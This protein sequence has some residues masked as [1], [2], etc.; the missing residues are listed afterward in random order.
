[1]ADAFIQPQGYARLNPAS[2][3]A[4]AAHAIV[5]GSVDVDV[6]TG[7]LLT[8]S[9]QFST[10]TPTL[11]ALARVSSPVGQA[12]A[13]RKGTWR[14]A[15]SRQVGTQSFVEFW[16][17]R[18]SSDFGNKG[19][20]ATDPTFATGSSNNA[21][22]I[23]TRMGNYS[24]GNAEHWGALYR[25]SD[26]FYG[27]GE[28][29]TPGVLTLL[30]VVRRQ[31][32]MELWRDGLLKRTVMVGPQNLGSCGLVV[33]AFLEN[34]Y[35]TSSSDMVLAGRSML[36]P[37]ADEIRAFSANLWSLFDAGEDQ[38]E[39]AAPAAYTLTAAGGAFAFTGQP[40]TLSTARR[41]AAA[42]GGFTLTTLAAS[43]LAA[44]RIVAAPAVLSLAGTAANLKAARRLPA[45]AGAVA[46]TG[47]A[48]KLTAA[49]KLTAAPAAFALTGGTA[50]FVYTPKPGGQGPTYTLTGGSGAFL[51][52]AT[53][54]RLLLAR[55]LV[56]TVG[57][58]SATGM[59]AALVA[60]RRLGALPGSFAFVGG[61]AGLRA[62]RRLAAGFGSFS[63]SGIAAK[64]ATARRL[65]ATT[66]SFAVAGTDALMKY[67]ANR[68]EID[69]D[70]STIP[71]NRT[72]V[73]GAFSRVVVFGANSRV[74]VF[75]GATRV[76]VF[77][78]PKIE[79][80]N[81]M[82]NAEEPY[83]VDGKWFCDKDP[84]EKS[85]FVADISKEL[86]KRHTTAVSVVVLTGGVTATEG[87]DIQGNLI[88]VKL[89]GMDVTDGA[90]NFWTARVTCA[91][92]EQFDRTTW[93]NK[94]DN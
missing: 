49:R 89:E 41:L 20:G 87:P 12:I 39:N 79:K 43:L 69:I 93:L 71:A 51:L 74:V 59:P 9:G 57:A 3:I 21:A 47:A 92:T 4:M 81:S 13:F 29:L 85:Y 23:V 36:D 25:W 38:D 46:L 26:V 45:A 22:A 88:V 30:V 72:V 65:P 78:D 90:D 61:A 17:G 50:T 84:D 54:A 52:T 2:R 27:A 58:F 73:F 67:S 48:A 68:G 63:A 14:A 94:V 37:S 18:P 24:D 34:D 60:A 82:A 80:E 32:R 70:A 28:A 16:Y 44:R 35:W 64:L 15:M 31:D 5:L 55:R 8:G 76:V 86:A 75:G 33:G 6:V 77:D 7:K 11:N 53:T 1:M 91:N 56:A 83:F 62:G 66:G 42:A 19:T 40:A 10:N